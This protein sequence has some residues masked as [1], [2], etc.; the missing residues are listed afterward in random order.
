MIARS[1]P[2]LRG[3]V[4]SIRYGE[5]DRSRRRRR[6]IAT[7]LAVFFS[8]VAVSSIAENFGKSPLLFVGLLFGCGLIACWGGK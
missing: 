2:T 3:Q 1:I 7:T 6:R 8:L 5:R 4:V